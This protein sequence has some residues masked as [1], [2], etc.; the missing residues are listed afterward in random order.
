MT[1]WQH[2]IAFMQ[3]NLSNL[4]SAFWWFELYVHFLAGC[5][6]ICKVTSPALEWADSPDG[7]VFVS[8]NALL[9]IHSVYNLISKFG[10]LSSRPNMPNLRVLESDKNDAA[11]G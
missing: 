1:L 11:N 3:I 8:P 5:A 4:T 10:A 2:Y 9:K 6:V 7:A